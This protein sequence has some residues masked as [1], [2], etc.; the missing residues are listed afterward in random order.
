LCISCVLFFTHQERRMRTLLH[1][2]CILDT[3]MQNHFV[4]TK[5]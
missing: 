2:A 3:M 4:T 1:G 5:C